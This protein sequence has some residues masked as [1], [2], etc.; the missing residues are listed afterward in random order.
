MSIDRDDAQFCGEKSVKGRS[1]AVKKL[2][3]G[4]KVEGVHELAIKVAAARGFDPETF[5]DP[6][7][8]SQ[9]PDPYHLK[10]MKEAVESFCDAVQ[11][12]KKIM[13]YGDYDVDG[14]TS[15]SLVLRWLTSVSHEKVIYYIP[16]RLAEGYGPNAN[17]IRR[18]HEE[19]GVEYLLCLDSG[20]TAHEPLGV[21]AELGMEIAIL[22]H[23]EPDDRDPPGILV[24]PKRRD[25]DRKFDYLCTAGL[26][27]LFLVG[28]QREMRN[29]GFFTEA[30]P[31]INLMRWLGIVAL[32]TVADLVP[33]VGLNRAYVA[34]GLPLMDHIP[35]LSALNVAN[36]D[37]G[38][39]ATTCGFK[40]GPCINA[41]G[42]IGDTRQGTYL[43]WSDNEEEV[44]EIAQTLVETNKQR[45][46]IQKNAMLNAIEMGKARSEDGVIVLYDPTW[47]PGV[48]GLVASKVKDAF[49][50][51]AVIIGAG[52][53]ASCRSV[54]GFDIGSAVIAAREAGILLKGGGHA[55]A[56]GLTVIPEK[57]DDL[58][59]FLC[60][61][62]I[63]FEHPPTEI[64]LAFKAGEL[65]P[66][67]VEALDSL[68]PFG[69]KNPKPRVAVLN[70]LVKSVRIMK[71]MHVKIFISEGG[72]ETEAM[73]WNA[74]G[75]PL[76][77]ALAGSEGHFVDI[78]GT[79]RVDSFGGKRRATVI[80][81]DA[82]IG[83]T[84]EAMDRDAA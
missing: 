3:S 39:T 35:G 78:Y 21:A 60:E 69:M 77:D 71:E 61:K 18:T 81:E 37:E 74:I 72:K 43:L 82:I 38:Y 12:D 4:P 10:S 17:A 11:A 55:M 15:T 62:A 84:F 34:V 75:T 9:M 22:D 83:G 2:A 1:W 24:N 33:L 25:E 13:I 5:F 58:R 14:A 46:D 63:G 8:K 76:G 64:D 7:I 65:D 80:V 54:D 30:R 44:K 45:Q 36:G 52:G 40:F 32:G 59:K 49:D 26:A 27:F 48:V 67:L 70:G 68:E 42:R 31:E 28:V 51:P 29:R 66:T 16:D 56:A 6:K 41:A 20:T 53:S 79:A 57:I 19:E 23:H 47:H 73:M 50:R